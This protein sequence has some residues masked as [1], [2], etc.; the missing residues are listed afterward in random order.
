MNARLQTCS[1]DTGPSRSYL[2]ANEIRLDMEVQSRAFQSGRPAPVGELTQSRTE[3]CQLHQSLVMVAT[4]LPSCSAPTFT[5]KNIHL[6]TQNLT[7]IEKSKK[8]L[9]KNT[10]ISENML[11]HWS[12]SAPGTSV[13]GTL[14]AP[15]ARIYEEDD[16]S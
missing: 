6:H 16:F 7:K 9:L 1:T 14:P 2:S 15:S 10:M 3:A 5:P 11:T 12:I 8:K 4:L 13:A